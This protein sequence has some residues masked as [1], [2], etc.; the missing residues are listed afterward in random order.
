MPFREAHSVVGK[1]VRHCIDSGKEFGD[2]TDEE[3][4][5]FSPLFGSD[6]REALDA[7]GA[8]ARRKAPGAASP[9]SVRGQL[10][11]YHKN[12]TGGK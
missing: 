6:A 5:A 2:L 7:R 9:A 8:M 1:L 3:F 4:A 11:K 12:K 10:K